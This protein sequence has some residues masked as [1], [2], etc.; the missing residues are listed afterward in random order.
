MCTHVCKHMVVLC[1][2]NAHF[3]DPSFHLSM[4]LLCWCR[5][6]TTSQLDWSPRELRL[7]F[8]RTNSLANS[9]AHNIGRSFLP[10]QSKSV[11]HPQVPVKQTEAAETKE[12]RRLIWCP[13][14]HS[15]LRW[16]GNTIRDRSHRPIQHDGSISKIKKHTHIYYIYIHCGR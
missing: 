8:N 13:G 3:L 2:F 5:W 7:S 15:N 10:S 12:S 4:L 14:R 11:A 6:F 16:H 1:D 9:L